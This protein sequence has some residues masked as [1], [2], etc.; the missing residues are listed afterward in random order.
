MSALR[1]IPLG[2]P[3][4]AEVYANIPLYLYTS[5]AFGSI[6]LAVDYKGTEVFN[7]V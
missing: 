4:L 6:C 7:T 3:V 1:F 2:L 5:K